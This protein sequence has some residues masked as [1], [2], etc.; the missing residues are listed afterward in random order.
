MIE[1][2]G[3]ARAWLPW[4][5][6][7]AA[8]VVTLLTS[9]E[10][11]DL[12]PADLPVVAAVAAA[13]LGLLTT[14]PVVGWLVS[15]GGALLVSQVFDVVD[16]DP[17]PWPAVH[18]LVLLALLFAAGIRPL[19]G[20]SEQVV[21]ARRWSR[22]HVAGLV[23]W[24]VAT[25]ATAALFGVSVPEHL[26]AG[27]T[28]GAA[29]VGVAGLVVRETGLLSLLPHEAP[30]PPGD[31][32]RLLRAGARQAFLD[33]R[34]PVQDGSAQTS[35]SRARGALPV[36]IAFGVFWVAVATV[37]ATV[38]V[39]PLLVPVVALAV[40]FPIV[41]AERRPL[42]GWRLATVLAVVLAL[43]GSPSGGEHYGTWPVVFQWTWLA[44][45]FF[46]SVRHERWTTVCV[47][48]TT[49]VAM[50]TG[51]PDDS[52][53]VVTLIVALTAAL[54]IGDLVRARR[55]TSRDLAEQTELSE[56]EKARRTVLEE[57]A[58][59]ARELHDVVAH[60]MSLVV[61]QAE[62]APYRI[63]GL[64]DA[65]AAEFASISASARQALDEIRGLLGVL[66]GT[67][68]GAALTP[69]PGLEQLGELVDGARRSG[70][71]V[72]FAISGT[73]PAQVSA[74]TGLAA[75]RIV[76]ESLA[77]AV[78]HASGAT[79]TVDV[80]Y[81]GDAVEVHIHNAAAHG[82]PAAAAATAGRG[83]AVTPPAAGHGLVG[84]RER[85]AVV[86]GTFEAGPAVDGGF[87]VAA[88]LP[89]EPR[90]S[91]AGTRPPAL[92]TSPDRP[93]EPPA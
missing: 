18:G 32:P 59:I 48:A 3:T 13:P 66:R 41:L 78:R 68:D 20:R 45:A 89:Y 16:G 88:V 64:P 67:D 1:Q 54:I 14:A 24:A 56:L 79:V 58:R 25:A 52:G 49:V 69:Q 35:T 84:M 8:F 57:R 12:A 21:T 72:E 37:E 87:S 23:V 73:A 6:A 2:R 91:P 86:G 29:A 93:E 40:A 74:A 36:V 19:P 85:A 30:I 80:A 47:W 4:L 11:L 44:S 62:T 71:T 5:G 50:T 15:A 92:A 28:V 81:G 39:H 27:W 9:A 76:Q 63:T 82:A 77:N 70:A 60:H 10:V 33:W 75:Y 53:T 22:E 34:A 46:V 65:A 17:W 31:L 61:V 42:A 83:R 7:A 90:H 26:T 51:V 55:R 43:A 38:A